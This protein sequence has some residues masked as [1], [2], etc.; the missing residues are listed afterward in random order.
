[1][2]RY[3][4]NFIKDN[5]LPVKEWFYGV[6]IGGVVGGT[7]GF[8]LSVTSLYSDLLSNNSLQRFNAIEKVEQSTMIGSSVGSLLVGTI[9]NP[10]LSGGFFLVSTMPIYIS[11]KVKNN[12]KSLHY[13][14]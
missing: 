2:I 14:R 9:C 6:T 10:L 1:M 5:T 4:K 13:Y 11:A 12:E 3:C 7:C 8:G